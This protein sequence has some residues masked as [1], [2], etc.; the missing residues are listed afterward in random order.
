MTTLR[1]IAMALSLSSIVSSVAAFTILTTACGWKPKA[2][3]IVFD[4]GLF[5]AHGMIYLPPFAILAFIPFIFRKRLNQD[6]AIIVTSFGLVGMFSRMIPGLAEIWY[7]RRAVACSV[8][9]LIGP[10][11]AVP[12]SCIVG[13]LAGT[14]T[15]VVAAW[16]MSRMTTR[17]REALISAKDDCTLD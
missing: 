10:F 17:A 12:M 8:D 3:L 5:L 4:P 15:G 14:A 1:C 13:T 16:A 2:A 7:Y 11:H 9:S 6:Q